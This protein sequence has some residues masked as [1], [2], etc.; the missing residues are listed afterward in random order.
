VAQKKRF[1]LYLYS[2]QFAIVEGFSCFSA[3]KATGFKSVDVD[4]Y[5]DLNGPRY[6]FDATTRKWVRG[7]NV[8][9]DKVAA[10]FKEKPSK[11]DV[12]VSVEEETT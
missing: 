11:L 12:D 1:V 4:F 6:Y 9:L 2:G 3:S 5:T 10:A 7:E 8:E